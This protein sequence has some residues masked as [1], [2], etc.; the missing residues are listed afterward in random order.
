[1]TALPSL[2][3]LDRAQD[4]RI[5][6]APDLLVSRC[7]GLVFADRETGV[8][9]GEGFTLNVPLAAGATD[10][11]YLLAFTELIEP[12]VSAFHPDVLLVSPLARRI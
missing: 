10:G 8:G 6:S 3:A 2:R 11:D 9:A 12:V 5:S 1:M 4:S 7:D